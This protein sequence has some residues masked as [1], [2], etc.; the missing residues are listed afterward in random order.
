MENEIHR[1]TLNTALAGTLFA[2][3]LYHYA[4]IG[5]TNTHALEQ[6]AA[7]AAHGSVYVAD[8]QTS[9]RGRGTHAWHS[10]SGAG[11]YISVLLRP[12]I[13]P[14]DAL[15]FSLAAGLAVQ[16]AVENVTAMVADIRWPNDLLL[17][18]RKFCGILTEMNAEPTKIRSA[19][20]GIGIN[21][22]HAYFPRE[23]ATQA[24]SLRYESGRMVQRGELLTAV[25]HCLSHELHALSYPQKLPLATRSI[26]QRLE[27]KSTWIRGKRV[28]V[29]ESGG[30]TGVT[31]GLD[32]WGFLR[33]E[34]PDGL[35]TVLSGGVR[36][37]K[38]P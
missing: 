25:L 3:K 24:T 28:H 27:Q 13:L 23:L 34:T 6:A 9:G 33:V 8:E 16:Q 35:R 21:V 26:L 38:A 22:N 5:S 29:N 4:T 1:D 14:G 12:D 37:Q 7:G 18:D 20:I 10:E 15:W 2:G 36:E 19:V 32:E 31:A 11:L 30:Y 17:G